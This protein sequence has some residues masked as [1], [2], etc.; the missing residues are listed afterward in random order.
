MGPESNAAILV[1]S[2]TPAPG[3]RVWLCL[4]APDRPRSS[5]GK[6]NLPV[7]ETENKSVDYSPPAS[8]PA[9]QS[10]SQLQSANPRDR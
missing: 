9:S 2:T 4:R 3:I 6:I 8:Q 5:R 10:V 1:L 7:E